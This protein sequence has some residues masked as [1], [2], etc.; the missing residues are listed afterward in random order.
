MSLIHGILWFLIV[1]LVCFIGW[2]RYKKGNLM[3]LIWLIIVIVVAV[4][5]GLALMLFFL[6]SKLLYQ[7]QGDYVYTPENI[8]LNYEAVTLK[9]SDDHSIAAWFIPAR[10]GQGQRTVLFCHGNAGNMSHRLHTLQLLH[11]LGLNCLIVDYRGYGQSPG[12]PT[13]RGTLLDIRAG[14]DWLVE[15]KGV[16]PEQIILFGRSLGGSIAATIA[17]EVDPGGVILESTFTCFVDIGKY[18]YPWLPVQWFVKFEYNT[19]DAVKKMKCPVFIVHSPDDEIVP[20]QFGQKL[21]EAAPEPKFFKELKG[22][23]NEGFFENPILYKKIWQEWI[24]LLNK[25][26]E[27]T[28]VVSA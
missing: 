22:G 15:E 27:E 4:Y 10:T 17:E 9:T 16:S 19:L 20:Y 14:W 24:D 3:G 21:Y 2:R 6:Q 13:E 23:H 28:S 26:T 7:P 25:M 18:Y 12:K 8:G 11:E 1:L 5:A